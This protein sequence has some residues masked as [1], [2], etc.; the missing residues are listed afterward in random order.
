M[1]MMTKMNQ[2]SVVILPQRICELGEACEGLRIAM[3]IGG[4]WTWRCEVS[5]NVHQSQCFS[6]SVHQE[7]S[8]S[9]F[10]MLQSNF[11]H[12]LLYEKPEL[13]QKAR[14]HVPEQQLWSIAEQKL[15]DALEAEP[16]HIP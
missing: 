6:L 14:C 3:R 11:Q 10:V 2:S 1:M 15:K 16:G 8:V 13:Q 9:F 5:I 12:V 7:S 4:G